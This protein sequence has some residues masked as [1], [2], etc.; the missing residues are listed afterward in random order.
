MIKLMFFCS[1]LFDVCTSSTQQIISICSS[2]KSGHLF[3]FSSI[4]FAN[5]EVQALLMRTIK[6]IHDAAYAP[7]GDLITYSPLPSRSLRQIDPFLFLNHHGPQKYRPGNQGLPFGPHPHRG[8][9][10]VTFILEGDIMHKDSE[11]HESVIKAG[12]VQWMT[13]GSGLIHAETSSDQ[14]KREGGD[15][16]ILQLWLNLP[17]KLK[18]TPPHYTGLQKEDIPRLSLDNDKVQVDLI[19]GEWDG[20]KGA[21]ESLLNVQL[22]TIF[23]KTGGKLV[24]QAPA[25][26]NVFFYVI[27][28]RLNVNGQPVEALKLVEFNNDGEK[29][30]VEATGSSVLLFGHAKPIG[31]PVVAY[32]PFVMNTEQEI[33]QAY[34]DY[35]KGKFGAWQE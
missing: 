11:G 12:G 27:R 25:D 7:I 14:F 2:D 17:A 31:E 10:T 19:S 4:L 9:E 23:F 13:A 18:M 26:H 34:D 24:L 33:K 22:N 30:E 6:K 29:I 21:F 15:M 1:M 20:K 35:R 3:I 28:G 5:F 8:M 16:E 32:G